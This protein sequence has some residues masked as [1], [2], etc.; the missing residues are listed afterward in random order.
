MH[1]N[2][3]KMIMYDTCFEYTLW[4]GATSSQ[5]FVMEIFDQSSIIV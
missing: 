1:A 2:D 4:S 5:G 3:F